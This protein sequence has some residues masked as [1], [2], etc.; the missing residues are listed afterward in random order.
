MR[1]SVPTADHG[2]MPTAT[3][4]TFQDLLTRPLDESFS[5][6]SHRSRS[7]LDVA[8]EGLPEVPG[9]DVAHIEAA[10]RTLVVSGWKVTETSKVHLG[11]HCQRS[12]FGFGTVLESAPGSVV[13]GIVVVDDLPNPPTGAL[14][15][16]GTLVEFG[17]QLCKECTANGF[18]SATVAD[19]IIRR[20][21]FGAATIESAGRFVTDL[22]T[23]EFALPWDTA[24]RCASYAAKLRTTATE[25]SQDPQTFC[26]DLQHRLAQLAAISPADIPGNYLARVASIRAAAGSIWLG[27]HRQ[28]E[29]DRKYLGGNRTL[30]AALT[31]LT[32]Q[33][34]TVLDTAR[35]VL[36]RFADELDQLLDPTQAAAQALEALD[37]RDELHE[38][39]AELLRGV[40][41]RAGD[42]SSLYDKRGTGTNGFVLALVQDCDVR[43][44]QRSEITRL[45]RARHNVV[46]VDVRAASRVS[47]VEMPALDFDYL[48]SMG[49]HILQLDSYPDEQFAVVPP[50]VHARVALAVFRAGNDPFPA[51]NFEH[52]TDGAGNFRRTHG[53]HLEPLGRFRYAMRRALGAEPF[54]VLH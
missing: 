40:W 32:T 45:L 44:L 37:D 10:I 6:G 46:D 27:D 21:R 30:F 53:R 29:I 15:V 5:T 14:P 4:L 42:L 2:H 48:R 19:E 43:R 8:A 26:A 25:L 34:H 38:Q 49:V 12:S 28:T 22:E 3:D 41:D 13:D 1:T 9:V 52:R 31:G 51:A 23:S 18:L 7:V 24:T 50:A 17:P 39:M 33:N 16:T 54:G 20:V 11:T 47:V 36:V 35:Y